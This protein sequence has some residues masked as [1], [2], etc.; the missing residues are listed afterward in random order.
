MT[1]HRILWKRGTDGVNLLLW[2][3]VSGICWVRWEKGREQGFWS[4]RHLSDDWT[5]GVQED[6]LCGVAEHGLTGW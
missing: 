5:F 1:I 4:V 3:W 6:L 2:G